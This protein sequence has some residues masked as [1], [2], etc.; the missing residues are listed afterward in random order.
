MVFGKFKNRSLKILSLILTITVLF[1]VSGCS[2][3]IEELRL[4]KLEDY[5]YGFADELSADPL[6][7]LNSNS[8]EKIKLPGLSDEQKEIMLATGNFKFSIEEL[9]VAEK[10]KSAD[11]KLK[12]S[13]IDLE[14]R[15][16]ATELHTVGQ[17]KKEI[18]KFKES[19][20]VLDFTLSKD[21]EG[22]KFDDL[23]EI[24]KYLIEPYGTLQV[25]DDEGF[26]IELTHEFFDEVF[27]DVLWYDPLFST[28]LHL[29]KLEDPVAIQC[30]FYFNTPV[31]LNFRAVLKDESGTTLADTGVLLKDSVIAVV[32]FSHDSLGMSGFSKGKYTIEI[33]YDKEVFAKTEEPLEIK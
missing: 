31:N 17:Y 30:A 13:I 26:P 8:A 11:C 6:T 29:N 32:D 27:I 25:C 23:N 10:G 16:S 19:K 9:N 20:K 7:V 28:P 3:Y 22:W 21:K 4:R 33:L 14:D 15:Y 2:G 5:I 24:V 18:S 12:F 1:S